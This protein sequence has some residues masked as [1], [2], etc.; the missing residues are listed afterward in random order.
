MISIYLFTKKKKV[1][2]FSQFQ[3]KL[4][5]FIVLKEFIT[6]F[7]FGHK[8]CFYLLLLKMN[9]FLQF[10]LKKYFNLFS[11]YFHLRKVTYTNY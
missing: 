1:N 9:E 8:Y 5:T 3:K 2:L 11:F 7:Q 10:Y 6:K 4:F